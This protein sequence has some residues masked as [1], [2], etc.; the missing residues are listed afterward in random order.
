MTTERCRRCRGPLLPVAEG[1]SCLL[2]GHVIYGDLPLVGPIAS[3]RPMLVTRGQRRWSIAERNAGRQ[4]HT[5]GG[6]LAELD[7]GDQ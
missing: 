5:H 6:P 3:P 1:L 2:C 7:G 4:R